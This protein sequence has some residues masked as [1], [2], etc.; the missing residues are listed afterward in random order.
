M[1]LPLTHVLVDPLGEGLSKFRIV[2]CVPIADGSDYQ[3]LL[4]FVSDEE[5]T[6]LLS[7]CVDARAV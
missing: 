2:D 6:E 5:R 7:V 1:G 4:P 3:S